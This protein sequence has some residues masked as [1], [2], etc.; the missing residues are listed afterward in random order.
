MRQIDLIGKRF[1]KLIVISYFGKKGRY[2]Y[3]NTKC[4][5]GGLLIVRGASLKSSNTESCGCIHALALLERSMIHGKART[6]LYTIW[7]NMK[8]R[9]L[10]V[11][12]Q[13]YIRYGGRGITVCKRWKDSFMEFYK[14][15]GERP[16]GMT[17]ER[18][19][20]NKGYNKSNCKWATPE[21]QANNKRN[22]RFV[23][24]RGIELTIPRW[25]KRLRMNKNTLYYRI[26]SGWSIQRAFATL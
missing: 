8:S 5:C 6:P 14:D 24:Y 16:K 17:L 10:N 2:T 15:M 22:N 23:R 19:D 3:W 20:N 18:I 11:K 7:S 1:G 13:S 4:D 12:Q 25:A 26:Q 21:E 9:C